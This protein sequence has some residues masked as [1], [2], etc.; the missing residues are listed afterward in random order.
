MKNFMKISG[1]FFNFSEF[2]FHMY[3]S[4]HFLIGQNLFFTT[5]I[6]LKVD[7]NNGIGDDFCVCPVCIRLHISRYIIIH[8]AYIFCAVSQLVELDPVQKY[9]LKA[10]DRPTLVEDF[11]SWH[12]AVVLR[13]GRRIIWCTLLS[14][15]FKKWRKYFS[16]SPHQ[17]RV[18]FDGVNSLF[19]CLICRAS[20]RENKTETKGKSMGQYK[21]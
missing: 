8:F 13:N 21:V 17:V 4:I 12:F 14:L 10:N 16:T 5:K 11:L 18:I 3:S 19:F 7:E 1:Q 20:P 9:F 15:F 2:F 6:R